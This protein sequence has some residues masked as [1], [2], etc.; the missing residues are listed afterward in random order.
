MSDGPIDRVEKVTLNHY[1]VHVSPRGD[2]VTHEARECVCGPTCEPVKCEDGSLG[3]LYVHHSL[4]G[5]E[6]IE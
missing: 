2:L 6:K 3:W 5:R 1:E 4:D